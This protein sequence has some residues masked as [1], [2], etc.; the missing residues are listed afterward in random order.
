MELFALTRNSSICF[1]FIADWKIASSLRPRE[2]GRYLLTSGWSVSYVIPDRGDGMP[3]NIP[4]GAKSVLARATSTKHFVADVVGHI[5]RERPK[6]VY[7]L[8]PSRKAKLIA[9]QVQSWVKIIG[10]W[11]DW[12]PMAR[13]RLPKKLALRYYD[14][15][16]R[17][18]ADIVTVAS[19]WLQEQFKAFGRDDAH[20]IPYAML[21]ESFPDEP[22][23]FKTPTAVFMGSFGGQWDQDV[24]FDAAM[25]MRQRKFEPAMTLIGGGHELEKWR[26]FVTSNHL[27][28]VT[29]PGFLETQQML[30]ALRH[31]HVLLFPIA[32]RPANWARCPFK[33]FQY[34]QAQRPIITCRIG[35]VV[36]TLGENAN[37]V[38]CNP[39]AFADAIELSMNQPRMPDV[40]YGIESHTWHN[41]GKKLMNL[42]QTIDTG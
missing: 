37:Y 27:Q 12:L 22:T 6:F 15:W 18:N 1:V 30:N 21:P 36:E 11:E 32:D 4:G 14:W 28:T 2:L 10:D 19:R 39:E 5:D 29:L 8:N 25:I 35:E 24:L 26:Q 41:R 33:V 16:F 17:H 40:D 7:F 20:Y 23:P 31:A 3:D 42:L 9:E 38:D 34:A 13:F